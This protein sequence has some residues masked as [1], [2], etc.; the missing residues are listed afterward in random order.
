[1]LDRGPVPARV[2]G[3]LDYVLGA[4]LVLA[5]F[6]LGFDDDTATTVSV[7]AGVAELL[8]G[9]TTAWGPGLVKL[10]PPAVHG[11][12]DYVFTAALIVAPFVFGFDGDGTALAFF[13]VVGIGG[14]LLVAATRFVEDPAP[15][16]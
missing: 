16:R 4:V 13:L 7:V 2:H 12:V 5:P 10:I 3:M 1:M 14:L 9:A 8:V 6:V 15:A 11:I